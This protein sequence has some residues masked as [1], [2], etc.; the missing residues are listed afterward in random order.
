MFSCIIPFISYLWYWNLFSHQHLTLIIKPVLTNSRKHFS[1]KTLLIFTY[2]KML[3]LWDRWISNS[4]HK[5][6]N[7]INK[8]N[9]KSSLC[10]S[11]NIQIFN[12][13]TFLLTA[14]K[15][16]LP[17]IWIG[18]HMV[19][20]TFTPQYECNFSTQTRHFSQAFWK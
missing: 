5:Y 3:L 16:I 18:N 19:V 6:S 13:F 12:A 11:D 10:H 20:A 1:L 9:F 17:T 15:T 4:Y 8:G 7:H 14:T 2:Q